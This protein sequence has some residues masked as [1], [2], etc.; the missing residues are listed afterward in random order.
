MKGVLK[1][2]AASNGEVIL[3]IDE[4]HNL[5]GA[6]AS[7]GSMDASN[8]L[9]PP[10]ARG[11]LHC[12]GATTTNEYRKY[13]E[14]DPALARRF[15]SIYVGEPNIENA[16]SMMR[17]LKEKYEVHHGVRIQDSA[18][19]SACVLSNRYITDRQLPDK[20][21]D[22]IDEAASRLRLQQESKPE[23]I[24][25][26][27]RVIIQMKIE[28]QALQKETDM[29]SKER[30]EKLKKELEEKEKEVSALS[31]KW[32]TE[33]ETISNIKSIKQQLEQARTDRD[34]AKREGNFALA[35]E[36]EYGV[37]P[38]L[39]RDLPKEGTGPELSLLSESVT[40]KDIAAV[41]ARHTGIPLS[42]LL[43]SEKQRLLHMEQEIEKKVIGQSRAVQAIANAVRV[44]RAGLNSHERPMGSFLFLGPTGVGK[45][46]LCK[47]LSNFL[48]QNPSAMV[49][50]DMSEYM[51]KF[52]VSRLIGAPP[53]YV[54]YE[55]G[56]VLT[57]AVRRRP[58]QVVLFDEFEKAHR[59]VSNVLLQ[60]LDEGF[61]TDSQGRKVDFRNTIVI[62][63]SNIGADLLSATNDVEAVKP[64][65]MERVRDVMLPEFINRIDEVV[66][67]NKLSRANMDDIVGVHLKELDNML[68]EKKIHIQLDAS[69][70]IWLADKGFDQ[71]Y[72]ARPLKRLIQKTLIQPLSKEILEGNIREYA[73]V[74]VH[75]SDDQQELVL[76]PINV[77]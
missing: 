8:M 46:M 75:V 25:N 13:I 59:E 68:L 37:I 34:R 36:L 63:T 23:S 41:V 49:R 67:F 17:A 27:D 10:L 38:K 19:V 6:G 57:E 73:N 1:D 71:M 28:I 22:L 14:K 29:A 16:I 39:E 61:L 50:I 5:V 4:L 33:R 55:E 48:F 65:V 43:G 70:R 58:Y 20:A 24:E 42:N 12:V 45:T 3:F 31:A 2:V 32:N 51:E 15:Q 7:E 72:G 60:V 9:K 77:S 26:L 30:L 11:E 76:E 44:S 62:M 40:E 18:V 53:G 47:E 35:S 69:A 74:K 66:V 52:S 64:A 54:G 21:I 56:G